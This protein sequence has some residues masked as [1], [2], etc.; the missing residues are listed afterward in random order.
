MKRICVFCGARTS[1]RPEFVELAKELG[2]ELAARNIGLVYGGGNWGLMGTVADAALAAGGE[3]VGIIP[4][5]LMG[6][7]GNRKDLTEQHIVDSLAIRKEMMNDYS[8]GFLTIPGGLG[9]MD[10]LFEVWTWRSLGLNV[11]PIGLLN[12]NGYYDQL[13]GFM[14]TVMAHELAGENAVRDHLII[15]QTVKDVLDLMQ[16]I[17]K[18]A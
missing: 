9:T 8:D 7:E 10:E 12:V 17:K 13:L 2:R 11:K 4:E 3:V 16:G 6:K 15:A 5:F 14:D 18:A 1:N